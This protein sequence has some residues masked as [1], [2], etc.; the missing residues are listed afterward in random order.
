MVERGTLN[1][2]VVGSNPTWFTIYVRYF[3]MYE[4]SGFTTRVI[5]KL[6]SVDRG[7]IRFVTMLTLYLTERNRMSYDKYHDLFWVRLPDNTY[8]VAPWMFIYYEEFG[9]MV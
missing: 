4:N 9:P 8:Q 6:Q 5:N 7:N 1:P 2:K 3:I